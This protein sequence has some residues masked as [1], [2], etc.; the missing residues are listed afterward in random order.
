MPEA[1]GLNSLGGTI[2]VALSDF[3]PGFW[4]VGMN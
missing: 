2:S 1:F 4:A 3:L